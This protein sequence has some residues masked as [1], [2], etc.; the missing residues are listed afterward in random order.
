LSPIDGSAPWRTNNLTICTIRQPRM[1]SDFTSMITRPPIP[2]CLD[3]PEVGRRVQRR[4]MPHIVAVVDI[5]PLLDQKLRDLTHGSPTVSP[6]P[7][8]EGAQIASGPGHLHVPID[9]AG[10][11]RR[12]LP[13]VAVAPQR[14]PLVHQILDQLEPPIVGRPEDHG[15][16]VLPLRSPTPVKVVLYAEGDYPSDRPR[17]SAPV[18]PLTLSLISSGLSLSRREMSSM[19]PRLAAS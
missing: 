18:C 11:E 19:L 4:P 7:F 13:L 5:G 2:T 9:G 12:V 16:V 17:L 10:V 15:P 14:S 8:S 3:L 6:P 1:G